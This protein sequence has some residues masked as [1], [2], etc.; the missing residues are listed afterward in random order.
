VIAV[1]HRQLGSTGLRVSKLTLGTMTF[2]LWFHTIGVL[3]RD[4]AEP[5]VRAALDAGVNFFDTVDIYSTGQSEEILGSSLKVAGIKRESLVI[6]SK[7]R[8]A[9]SAEASQGTGDVNN[10]GLSRK[11]I[12]ASCDASLPRL[13]TDY[14][15]L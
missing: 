4:E 12:I 15:D 14:I 8:G 5:L 13:G 9:M 6:A 2:R 10:V 11:H 1:R 7:V 3:G